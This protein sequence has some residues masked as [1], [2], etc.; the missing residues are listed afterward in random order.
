MVAILLSCERSKTY[1]PASEGEISTNSCLALATQQL[2]RQLGLRRLNQGS[3]L[4]QMSTAGIDNMGRV[5]IPQ[6]YP[7]S[8]MRA[9]ICQIVMDLPGHALSLL[10]PVL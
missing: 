7:I 9:S 4:S 8:A 6:E 5:L 1:P 3:D 2:L 10:Q